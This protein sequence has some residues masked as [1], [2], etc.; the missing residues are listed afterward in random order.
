MVESTAQVL[1]ENQ[2]EASKREAKEMAEMIGYQMGSGQAR[3]KVIEQIQL[4]IENTHSE[5]S[6]ICVFDWSGTEICH[7]DV[8]RVGQQ[9]APDQSMVT[10][11]NG[12]V[13]KADFYKLIQ[14]HK[15]TGG[16]RDF[17]GPDNESEIVYLHPVNS[18]DLIVG[19]HANIDR[20]RVQLGSLR[21][22]FYSI[23]AI[24]GL[25]LIT[26]SVG[27]VRWISSTYEIRLETRNRTLESEVVNLARLNKNL[28]QYQERI[29]Q[30]KPETD[31]EELIEEVY[32]EEETS[33][34]SKRILTYRR[35]EIL[36]VFINDISY[37]YTENAITYVVS[38]DGK[39]ST[40][41]SSLDE[42]FSKLDDSLFYRAN[43]QFIVAITAIDKI[44]K[45]GNNQLKIKITPEP[46]MEIIISKNRASEFK[47]WLSQ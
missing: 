17:N 44:L 19:A 5:N 35:N 8:T 2:L 38:T 16:I 14:S 22:R 36:P 21:S 6:F 41:N 32:V 13:S 27:A 43:R 1:I 33:S 10:T 28:Q 26:L 15:P 18:T 3:Q 24:M 4:S 9:L 7:P 42:L 40:T 46:E 11:V 29:S 12:E 31:R 23:F 37:I 30:S 47:Q 39:K 20:I 45:Y 25:V 34:L